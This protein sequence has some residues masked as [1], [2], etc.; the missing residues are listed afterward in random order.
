M[1]T[2]YWTNI[3]QILGIYLAQIG[4]LFMADLKFFEKSLWVSEWLSENMT[5][6]EAIASKNVKTAMKKKLKVKALPTAP[7]SKLPM[8]V[9]IKSTD[10]VH[11]PNPTQGSRLSEQVVVCLVHF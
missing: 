11:V 10:P 6:R 3:R 4:Q 5:S 9:M 1:L 7:V 2:K 8:I